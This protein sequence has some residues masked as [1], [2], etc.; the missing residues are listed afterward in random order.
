MVFGIDLSYVVP[1][2]AGGYF[3]LITLV[4]LYFAV[5]G[6][7]QEAVAVGMETVDEENADATDATA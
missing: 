3:V 6:S 4:L 7:R 1:F 2:V 5:L